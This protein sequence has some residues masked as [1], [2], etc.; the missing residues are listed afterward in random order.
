MSNKKCEDQ[1][2]ENQS[3][4]IFIP[5]FS[6]IVKVCTAA[7]IP[8]SVCKF[9]LVVIYIVKMFGFLGVSL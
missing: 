6:T 2:P 1:F 3:L 7:Q 9:K 8:F 5:R 4:N